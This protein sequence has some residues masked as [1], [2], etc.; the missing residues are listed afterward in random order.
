MRRL[1]RHRSV[2][3]AVM[4]AVV[5]LQRSQTA[6]ADAIE[7]K[8]IKTMRNDQA[9]AIPTCLRYDIFSSKN[10]KPAVACR[11]GRLYGVRHTGGPPSI[12]TISNGGGV[13]AGISLMAR[14]R[15]SFSKRP[16]RFGID[17]ALQIQAEMPVILTTADEIEPGMKAPA[18]QA[19]TLQRPWPGGALKMA[20]GRSE[21]R[22]SDRGT[23]GPGPRPQPI[24]VGTA[25]ARQL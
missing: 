14:N 6:S 2:G 1:G 4:G 22:S 24:C 11:T 9:T 8:A 16:R 18:D 20:S 12:R 21:V 10:I 3:A 23:T 15:P 5:S 25:C 17:L 13:S 7:P 19:L